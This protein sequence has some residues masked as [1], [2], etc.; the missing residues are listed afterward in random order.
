M[1]TFRKLGV[2]MLAVVSL[3]WFAGCSEVG[4]GSNYQNLS[5]VIE[6]NLS[7]VV[8]VESYNGSGEW[9][10]AGSGVIIY[11]TPAFSLVATNAH[12]VS[13]D[14]GNMIAKSAALKVNVTVK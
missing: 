11:A 7:K 12:V 4:S 2:L 6:A 9:K 10:S 13:D 3:I 14:S 5:Y 1:K 8:S